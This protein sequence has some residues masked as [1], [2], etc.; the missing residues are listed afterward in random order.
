MLQYLAPIIMISTV[1]FGAAI[2]AILFT[3]GALRIQL[4]VPKLNFRSFQPIERLRSLS[5]WL[6]EL[7]DDPTEAA[8]A[9]AS[10]GVVIAVVGYFVVNGWGNIRTLFADFYANFAAELLSIAVTVL[11]IDRLAARRAAKE[12][13]KRI[14]RQLGSHSNEFALEAVR[15]CREN[16]WL[17]DDSLKGTV[18]SEA[19]LKS[20]NLFGAHLQDADLEY[21]HLEDA[22]LANATLAGANLFRANLEGANLEYAD[23]EGAEL[24]NANLKYAHLEDAI[25]A[26]ASLR[27]ADLEGAILEDATYTSSTDWPDGFDPIKAGA[28]KVE[29]PLC[30]P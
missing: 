3:F 19:N 24:A 20:A 12:E 16:G 30:Q 7:I 4:P 11:I 21:A 27:D 14:I 2:G 23:L 26:D 8:I 29:L 5:S 28:V 15:L 10:A 9:F 25:L 1:V 22:I 17:E 13:K 6:R 18:L